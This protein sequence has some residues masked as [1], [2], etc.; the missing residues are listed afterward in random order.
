MYHE[1]LV[2]P[3][4]VMHDNPRRVMVIGGGE[5]AVLRELCHYTNIACIV[6][7]DIDETVVEMCRQHLPEWHRG[8]FDDL[9]VQLFHMDERR[10]LEDND[11]KFDIIYSDLTEPYEDGPSKL[12][13]PVSFT[14]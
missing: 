2:H 10:Y 5:G 11:Q 4:A 7:V 14:R 3:A 1:A 12:F 13:L 9:R 6:M 8:C